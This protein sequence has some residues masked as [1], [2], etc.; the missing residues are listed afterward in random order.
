M[1]NVLKWAGIIIGYIALSAIFLFSVPLVLGFLFVHGLEADYDAMNDDAESALREIGLN[2]YA[3]YATW[4]DMS[5]GG[6]L[7]AFVMPQY[8][9]YVDNT[10]L[11]DGI[12]GHAAAA[13]EWEVAPVTAGEYAQALR[14]AFPEAAFLLPADVTFDA[15]YEDAQAL[16]FFDQDTG[17]MICLR[18][19]TQPHTGRIKAAGLTI[20]HNGFV[21]ETETHG[22]FHG[23]GTT[24]QAFIVAEDKRAAFE[25]DLAAHV[26]WHAG[27]VTRAEYITM[28]DKLFFEVPPLYPQSGVDFEWWCYVDTF[29]RMYPDKA[30][31]DLPD[32][33]FPAA[34]QAAGAHYAGNWLVALYDADTGLMVFFQYDS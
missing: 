23:D 4:H 24:F 28:H 5:I 17:L 6:S 2:T 25:A 11:W 32:E 26:D 29:D 9:N 20:P 27:T 16:A 22:G 31:D 18:P 14:A 15:W 1:K 8:D 10:N 19:G 12:M 33:R 21:Y 13:A 3:E 30:T 34:M 7:T